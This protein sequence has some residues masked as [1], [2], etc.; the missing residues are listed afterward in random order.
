MKKLFLI[1][2]LASVFNLTAQ[3]DSIIKVKSSWYARVMPVSLYT[4]SGYIQDKIMQNIEVGRSFGVIDV[5]VAYG[6]T[7]LRADS[8]NFVEAKVTMDACQYGRFSNEIT[9]GLGYVMKSNTPIMLEVD[10]TVFA[11]VSK[12]WGLGVVIGYVDYGGNTHDSNKNYYGLYIRYGL[13]RSDGGSL[14]SR[15][16]GHHGK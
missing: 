12:N 10:Y 11:Q 15:I 13:Q 4:G 7:N 8:N 5:G 16:R 1:I 2:S 3:K 6:R 14:L 9:V